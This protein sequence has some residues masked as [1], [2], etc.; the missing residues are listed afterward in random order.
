LKVFSELY[1]TRWELMYEYIVL[2]SIAL[3]LYGLSRNT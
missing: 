3:V 1:L 2:H